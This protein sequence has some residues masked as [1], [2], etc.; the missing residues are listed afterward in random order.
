MKTLLRYCAI[1]MGITSLGTG[2]IVAEIAQASETATRTHGVT[3][4]Q[5][6]GSSSESLETE[7][8]SQLDATD[9]VEETEGIR[10]APIT[11]PAESPSDE[12]LDE[13]LTD[14]IPDP[15]TDETLTEPA[16][17]LPNETLD[18][19]VTEPA[20]P[21]DE[22]VETPTTPGMPPEM[23]PDSPGEMMETPT[24][25]QEETELSPTGE[26][27]TVDT[28]SMSIVDV[29]A[30]S[31][32]FMTLA[33]AIQ[34]AGLADTLSSEGPYTVFAP[35]DDAFAALPNG[36]LEML[37]QP[38]NQALLQQ[39]LQYHVVAG[40]ELLA[41]EISDGGLDTL[42]G[43]LA[44]RVT[45]DGRV[46]VND[47]SVVEPNIQASNGVIHGI[48]RV[49]LSAPLRDEVMDRLNAQPTP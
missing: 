7:V 3:E 13:T 11:D 18:N 31:Q 9:E 42:N 39:V 38:E 49:L 34:S 8:I 24:T 47:G 32:T 21:F 17:T 33:Q 37:L 4:Q 48:N 19:P 12:T 20:E 16:E 25:G 14:P 41:S 23:T 45:D 29:A 40:E 30:N 35:T 10:N 46:I 5:P 36:T 28:S 44:V 15:T 27:S 2:A 1:A 22:E 6:S 26:P 43:G